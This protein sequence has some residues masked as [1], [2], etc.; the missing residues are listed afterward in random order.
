ME[1]MSEEKINKELQ[2][3]I[4]DAL[5]NASIDD[6]VDDN[7]KTT[8]TGRSKGDEDRNCCRDSWFKCAR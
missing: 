4:E 8:K 3:E 1:F 7:P 6:L 5:G 2:A